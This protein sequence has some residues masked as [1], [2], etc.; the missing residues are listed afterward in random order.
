M[1]LAAPLMIVVAEDTAQDHAERGRQA[2]ARGEVNAAEAELRQA[3]RLAP[4]DGEYLALLGVV[5]GMQHKLQESDTYL[6][7][8]LHLDPA[9]SATRRNL[10][11]NQ[12]QLGQL[13]PAKANLERVVKQQPGDA[14]AVLVLGM[15]HEELKDY[16]AAI[17]LLESVPEQVRQRP[18]SMAALARAYYYLGRSGKARETLK[19]LQLHPQG[20][21][22]VFL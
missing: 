14:Q 20:P 7:K 13:A 9:D 21:E 17:R 15:V 19:E 16:R 11:W 10:G 5:L 8:A 18:E 2:V 1:L 3:V 4:Q 12:F 22:G 6:E